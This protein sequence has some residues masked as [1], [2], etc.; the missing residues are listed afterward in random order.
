MNTRVHCL[1]LD[2]A[3]CH[4]GRRGESDVTPLMQRRESAPALRFLATLAKG[5]TAVLDTRQ[6][7]D[8]TLKAMRDDAGFHSSAIAFV[9]DHRPDLLTVV[10]ATGLG[11]ALHGLEIPRPQG[12]CWATMMAKRPLHAPD[13][14]RRDRRVFRCTNIRSAI[15]APLIAD[16]EAIGTLAAYADRADAFASD[17]L[18]LLSVIAPYVAN[19]FAIARLQSRLRS[20][21]ETDS[22]TGLSNRRHFLAALTRELSRACRTAAPLTVALLDLDGFKALNDTHGHL[23]GDH[24]LRQIARS[25]RDRLRSSDVLA[26][27]GGDEFA[28]LLPETGPDV[29][30]VLRHLAPISITVAPNGQR[31][32]LPVSWGA[33][34]SPADGVDSE[35]LLRTADVRLYGM[36][37]RRKELPV[38]P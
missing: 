6:L 13:V 2:H 22:L 23:A 19:L 30:A 7:V 21:A 17:D 36:K 38:S 11:S 4:Q 12:S 24:A 20:L 28:V 3:G 10:G 16:G 15:C 35:A 26:R 8:W 14:G 32:I 34:S 33:A 1:R 37:R 5:L 29:P 31:R 9:G 27:F 25:L 18:A